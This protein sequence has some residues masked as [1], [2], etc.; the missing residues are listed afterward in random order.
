MSRGRFQQFDQ[1]LFEL[2]SVDA[3]ITYVDGGGKK[4]STSYR[5]LCDKLLSVSTTALGSLDISPRRLD[6]AMGSKLGAQLL[7]ACPYRKGTRR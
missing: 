1:R 7:N 4:I 5:C 2:R 6:A 3:P